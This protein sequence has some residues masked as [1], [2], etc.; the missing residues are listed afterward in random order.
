M[1][2]QK[3]T[4]LGGIGLSLIMA[5][6]LVACNPGT[7]KETEKSTKD[8]GSQKANKTEEPGKT[9]K[10]GKADNTDASKAG[11]SEAVTLNILGPGLFAAIGEKDKEDLVTGVKTTGYHAILER[12]KELNPKITLNIEPTGWDNWQSVITTAALSGDVDVILHGASIVDITEDLAPYIEKTKGFAD[13]V[14]AYSM[15]H[16][17]EDL[18][19]LKVSGIP[20]TVNPNAVWLNVQKFENFGVELPEPGWTFDDLLKLA[21]KLTGKDPVTGTATYGL[22]PL[23]PGAVSIPINFDYVAN[24][25]GIKV[26]DYKKD[27]A[28]TIVDYMKNGSVDAFNIL[29]KMGKYMSPE[30]KEGSVKIIPFDENAYWAIAF[31][32]TPLSN[33]KQMQANGTEGKF[34]LINLPVG[35]AGEFKGKPVCFLGDNNIAIYKDSKKKDWAWEFIKFMATDEGAV[36]WELDAGAIPNSLAAKDSIAQ[37]YGKDISETLNYINANIPKNFIS[38]ENQAYCTGYGTAVSSMATTVSNLFNGFMTAEEAA[39]YMQQISDEY[40]K[41]L[42][43]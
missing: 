29:A 31:T 40:K 21:E 23:D 13:S 1:R 22:R 10:P 41:S 27:Y 28:H 34:K 25:L 3:G 11:E 39:Q 2:K 6:S 8:N 37:K 4:R 19:K 5:F 18:T 30:D 43:G 20:Y 7:D 32:T 26:Y 12:W 14:V 35:T 16:Y 9:E 33:V 24:A 42:G 15:R 17:K 36:Q 38:T